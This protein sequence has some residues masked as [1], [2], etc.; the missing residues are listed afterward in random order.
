MNKK[1]LMVT[2]AI[3]SLIL[4]MSCNFLSA[5]GIDDFFTTIDS[6]VYS[7]DPDPE[8]QIMETNF[9]GSLE[10]PEDPEP[11][12]EFGGVAADGELN[13]SLEEQVNQGSHHYKVT[14]ETNVTLGGDGV[15]DDENN[16]SHE[17]TAD[18]V[19]Y[20]FDVLAP[21]FFTKTSPHTYEYTD[22]YVSETLVYTLFGYEYDSIG[23][24]GA[25][26]HFTCTLDE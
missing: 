13:L 1:R 20:T 23:H 24:L 18:G 15:V 17:F 26:I 16:A 12:V 3:L 10:E 5:I 7:N 6:V 22:E 14:G 4:T 11:V 9:P 2:I 8:I 19:N 25:E 21:K